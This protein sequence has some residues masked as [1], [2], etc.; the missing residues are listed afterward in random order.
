MIKLL[1]RIKKKWIKL[2]L[3]PIRVFC[4]H[5]TSETYD[6]DVYCKPDWVPLDFLKNFVE[7]LQADGY[8]FIS[9]EDAHYHISN[10]LM[11]YKKYAVLTADDGLRCQ[12]ALATWLNMR[13]IPITLFVNL[14]TLDGKTCGTQIKKYFNI[15]DA[16]EESIH[17]K[18]LYIT[19][20]DLKF[21]LPFVS[22]GMHGI[23]HEKVNNMSV[24]DFSKVVSICK[25]ELGNNTNYI[26]F[27]AYTHGIHSYHTDEILK[28]LHVIPVLA[29]GG[30]NYNDSTVIHRE[31]LEYIYK[32][33]NQLL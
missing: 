13:K 33:Q 17:A 23:T 28:K 4:F 1:N 11:R 32:C 18:E 8:D 2:R 25:R 10:D 5:Q 14:E 19:E 3:R 27:Y 12:L 16:K 26:P 20:G 15:T 22:I 9:L 24:E 21:L 29:D 6:P 7:Q 31:I 30:V